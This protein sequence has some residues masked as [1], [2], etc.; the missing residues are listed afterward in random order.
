MKRIKRLR[1]RTEKYKDKNTGEE[2]QGYLTVG[3]LLEKPDGDLV[4]KMDSIP[5]IF[6]GWLFC[7]D[8]E[9]K[10]ALQNSGMQQQPRAQSQPQQ[11]QAEFP[12]EDIPF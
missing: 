2:K 5:V 10:Q 12:E 7:G 8:L 11:Q 4:V 1:A 9:S 6:D 3:Y